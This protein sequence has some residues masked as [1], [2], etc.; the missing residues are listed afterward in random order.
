M[1]TPIF[2]SAPWSLNCKKAE[3]ALKEAECEYD[4][5][6]LETQEQI[7]GAHRDF[8]ISRLPALKV[9]GRTYEGLSEVEEF[10]IVGTGCQ[11]QERAKKRT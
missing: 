6:V 8:G 2:F 10:L 1:I 5:I 9:N 3:D 4:E 11:D 7:N